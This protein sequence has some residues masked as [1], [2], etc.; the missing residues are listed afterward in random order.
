[1]CGSTCVSTDYC[2]AFLLLGFA[3]GSDDSKGGRKKDRK[4]QKRN[5]STLSPD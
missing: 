2:F 4:N 5:V 1:M 3:I